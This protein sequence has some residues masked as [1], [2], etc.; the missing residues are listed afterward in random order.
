MLFRQ[1]FSIRGW[2]C[3]RV[4][5][6]FV[7]MGSA[8]PL[9]LLFISVNLNFNHFKSR[10]SYSIVRF[11]ECFN[12]VLVTQFYTVFCMHVANIWCGDILNNK[13]GSLVFLRPGGGGKNIR[14]L[15]V[16]RGNIIQYIDQI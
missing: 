10:Q 13:Y 3:S 5:I 6:I 4:F 16:F 2:G 8:H 7:L 12:D 15:P 14:Q 11:R 1:A 9:L